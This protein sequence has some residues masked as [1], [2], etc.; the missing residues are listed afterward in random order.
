MILHK[1]QRKHNDDSSSYPSSGRLKSLLASSGTASKN[2]KTPSRIAVSRRKTNSN[3][4]ELPP[5]LIAYIVDF[6][7]SDTPTLLACTLVSQAFLYPT[8]HHLFSEIKFIFQ[9]RKERTRGYH[10]LSLLEKFETSPGIWPHVRS[11]VIRSRSHIP[12]PHARPLLC[13]HFLNRI[14]GRLPAVEHV[15]IQGCRFSH[16]SQIAVADNVVGADLVTSL[17]R[18]SS[19]A[20]PQWDNPEACIFQG[21]KDHEHRP[22]IPLTTLSVVSCGF[23]VDPK[24][25]MEEIISLFSGCIKLTLSAVVTSAVMV[26]RHAIKLTDKQRF[27]FSLIEQFGGG[28]MDCVFQS[29]ISIPNWH[30]ISSFMIGLTNQKMFEDAAKFLQDVGDQLTSLDVDATGMYQ[31]TVIAEPV[32]WTT[33]NVSCCTSLESLCLN[34]DFA[35]LVCDFPEVLHNGTARLLCQ[36]PIDLLRSIKSDTLQHVVFRIRLRQ[37]DVDHF[38]ELVNWKI[39]EETLL[40]FSRLKKFVIKGIPWNEE[41][42]M[43]SASVD[44]CGFGSYGF[45]L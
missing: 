42:R 25:G 27:L 24:Y 2:F 26:S 11:L 9:R 45:V 10:F 29:A 1:R 17:F 14:L 20:K 22:S 12:K 44:D 23:S 13:V 16:T 33:F 32:D 3:G 37:T 35:V 30:Y 41:G 43:K 28:A 7:H 31:H 34:L 21:Q 36:Y 39:L 18:R 4:L 19:D 8:R 15:E 6:L 38:M 5:E 40:G